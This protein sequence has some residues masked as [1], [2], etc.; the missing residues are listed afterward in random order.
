MDNTNDMT[1]EIAQGPAAATSN[2]PPEIAAAPAIGVPESGVGLLQVIPTANLK[3]EHGEFAEFH[4]DYVRNYINLADN[5]A[6]WAF[7]IA[8]GVLAYLVT[9]AGIRSILLTPSLS[10][11]FSVVAL[12]ILLL[13]ASAACSFLVVAPR[14]SSPSNEGVVFFGAVA[15]R[16]SA[17][18][19]IA[20]VAAM[21]P[22]GLTEARIKHCFDISRVCARKY[23]FLR[24][25]IW[26]GVAALVFSLAS[27]SWMPTAT[28]V[29][30]A[31]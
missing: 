24:I 17:A 29:T 8:G 28:S 22:E 6:A 11:Q 16:K 9:D 25:A 1:H 2:V 15:K 31:P 7:A 19:Y 30:G 13:C 5:K 3:A 23:F 12:S 10:V 20:D 21:S 4:E 27:I 18:S 26:V 14:L